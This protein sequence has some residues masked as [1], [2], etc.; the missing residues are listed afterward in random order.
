MFREIVTF[1]FGIADSATAY[2]QQPS[3]FDARGDHAARFHASVIRPQHVGRRTAYFDM[4]IDTV[5]KRPRDLAAVVCDTIAT[6]A[7]IRLPIAEVAAGTVFCRSTNLVTK[8]N[9]P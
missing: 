8:M 4:Q 3:D 5:Q 2:M 9:C 1:E 6:A 7:A